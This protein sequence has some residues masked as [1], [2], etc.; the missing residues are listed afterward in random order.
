M[1]RNYLKIAWRN[2]V[3]HKLFSFINIGGLAVG[4]AVSFMLLLY[5][6][7]EFT[8]DKHN[9]KGDRI[10]MLFRNQPSESEIQTS[11]SMPVQVAGA[12]KKDFPEIEKAAR[13]NY[14]NDNLVNYNGKTLKVKMLS[15]DPELLDIFTY[16]FV[17]GNK[18]KVFDD[19]ASVVLTESGAKAIFGND[20]A[21]GKTFK[22]NKN[23]MVKV[24]GIIKDIPENASLRFN[25]LGSWKLLEAEQEW[26]KNSGWGNYS[27]K[28]YALLK[29][30]ADVKKLNVKMSGLIAKNDVYNKENKLFLF[31]F[32][33]IHLYDKFENGVNTGGDIE[34]IRLFMFLAIGILLIAC[35]NFMNLSTARSENRAR[36]VGVRKVVGARRISLIKQFMGESLLMAVIS[37]VFA[38]VIITLLLPYFNGIIQKNLT[39]PYTAPNFWVVGL[40]ITIITGI[41]AGSY[42]ALF[43]SAFKPVRVLKGFIK[44]GKT[45]LRPRQ[46]LVII[47]FAFATCLILSTILI[48]NQIN[49][50]KNRPAGYDKD[51]LVEL[52]QEGTLYEK[53]EEFRRDAIASGAI[54][55]GSA[56]SGTITIDG[57]SSW[58]VKWPGQLP[59]EDKIPIDQ[60]VTT[61][62]FTKTFG[63]KILKGRDFDQANPS[64]SLAIMM[65]E[66]AVK[67]MRLKEP[68]GQIVNWQGQQR[69]V[70]G[71]IKDFIW[72]APGAPIKPLIVGYMKEWNGTATLR[73][74]PALSVSNSLAKLEAVYK[75]YNPEYPFEYKFVDERYNDKFRTEQLLGTLANSFTILAI[76]ISCLGL[77]G[78]ASFSAEQRRK[79]I[80]I[81][82]VL[83]ASIGS[84]WFN[85]S[86]EFIQLVLIA[87]F[88]GAAF[89]WYFMNE[90]L[91]NYTYHT[92]I[93]VW[94]FIIT[95]L[96]SLAVTI[97]TV[98]W[99]AIKAAVTNPVKSLRSE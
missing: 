28:T 78:L 18:Q 95:I 12:I 56:T 92:Q 74:N 39:V 50:I 21:M 89:S 8:F 11:N 33:R 83:G 67:M 37:F 94:V 17:K 36:E 7:N 44:D 42:P 27:F 5:V 15:A 77:F 73:L 1:F 23:R 38:L 90:W 19:V 61:Y 99:Q 70:V 16:Q 88:I 31:P 68:L 76:V 52:S 45:S 22:L 13:T 9:E 58:G 72:G 79:E 20:E 26:V 25:M 87:F 81:R 60:L 10:Y 97:T 59:G 64:D 47:Q 29:P 43:L 35:I 2:L 14:P 98:S 34:Y 91:S 69:T 46:V 84:L 54:I 4:M 96:I 75:T 85:L 30:G 6:Y 80:G 48:Y 55:E 53:F 3:K 82:K 93:S 57:S 24:T 51:G 40:G 66:S 62:H 63:V 65:N 41:I 71:I 86:K 32:E 49:Y